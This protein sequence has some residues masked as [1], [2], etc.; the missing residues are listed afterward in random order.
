MAM[1]P[2][3]VSSSR[4]SQ[5]K[6][7]PMILPARAGRPVF[8]VHEDLRDMIVPVMSIRDACTADNKQGRDG[9]DPKP[10]V[11]WRTRFLVAGQ[12]GC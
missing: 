12:R 10:D 7:Q 3:P 2:H 4:S 9:D 5:M 1:I 6:I 11:H 8:C